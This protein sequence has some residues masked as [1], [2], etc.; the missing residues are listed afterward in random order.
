MATKDRDLVTPAVANE[1][2]NV[3]AAAM[4]RAGAAWL[5]ALTPPQRIAAQLGSPLEPEVEAERL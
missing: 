3:V 2:R 4:E 5:D 1:P